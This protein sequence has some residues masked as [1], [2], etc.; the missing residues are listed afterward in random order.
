MTP[1]KP[2]PKAEVRLSPMNGMDPLVDLRARE[3][4]RE[5]TRRKRASTE[6]PQLRS[7]EPVSDLVS[8]QRR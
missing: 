5:P 2:A 3:L 6:H 7:L 4:V 8:E 1:D